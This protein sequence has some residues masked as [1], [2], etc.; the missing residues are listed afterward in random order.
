MGEVP[1]I[2]G[3]SIRESATEVEKL[4]S[5]ADCFSE[6]SGFCEGFEAELASENVFGGDEEES[7]HLGLLEEQTAEVEEEEVRRLRGVSI[8]IESGSGEFVIGGKEAEEEHGHLG[9]LEEKAGVEEEEIRR[10]RRVSVGIE[11]GSWEFAIGGKEAEEEHGVSIGVGEENAD[12]VSKPVNEDDQGG[13]SRLSPLKTSEGDELGLSS[14]VRIGS[15]VSS[16][17]GAFGECQAGNGYDNVSGDCPSAK[18]GLESAKEVERDCSR[19]CEATHTEETYEKLFSLESEK[20][21]CD[22][23]ENLESSAF[24][25]G[26]NVW[27]Q[28]QHSGEPPE[29]VYN[30]EKCTSAHVGV[31]GL[32]SEAVC[33]SSTEGLTFEQQPQHFTSSEKCSPELRFVSDYRGCEVGG[34]VIGLASCF[35][36]V[37][38][39]CGDTDNGRKDDIKSTTM[40]V[41]RR[42]NPKRSASLR[43]N[44]KDGKSEQLDRTRNSGRRCR[45]KV[46]R[47]APLLLATVK[48]S[49]KFKRKRSFRRRPTSLSVWG[50]VDNL[51]KVFKQNGEL[52]TYTSDAIPVKIVRTRKQRSAVDRKNRLRA[53]KDGTKVSTTI[54]DDSSHQPM[55]H[56]LVD[57][58][59]SYEIPASISQIDVGI[60]GMNESNDKLVGDGCTIGAMLLQ[61]D[62]Q[63]VDKDLE[64]TL[65]QETSIDHVV[66]ECP[67]VS[68]QIGPEMLVEAA[69]YRNSL[70]AGTSPES[71]VCHPMLDFGLM[72]SEGATSPNHASVTLGVG[73]VPSENV[74]S[75]DKVTGMGQTVLVLESMSEI[76]MQVADSTSSKTFVTSLSGP[77][78]DS[79]LHTKV[80]GEDN[81]KASGH[82]CPTSENIEEKSDGIENLNKARK[83]SRYRKSKQKNDV[84][85]GNSQLCSKPGK[86]T[87]TGSKCRSFPAESSVL[88]IAELEHSE[89][90]MKVQNFETLLSSGQDISNLKSDETPTS[91]G[92]KGRKLPRSIEPRCSKNGS[93]GRASRRRTNVHGKKKQNAQKSRNKCISKEKSGTFDASL[94][95]SDSMNFSS[96]TA[97]L[98]MTISMCNSNTDAGCKVVPKDVPGSVII[99]VGDQLAPK[100]CNNSLKEQSLSPQLAWV[101]CDDC[102]K[103]RCISVELANAIDETNCKWTCEDNSD[104]AFADC[105]IPQEKTN[106]EI[107]AELGISDEDE[108]YS[109]KPSS[110]G[111]EPP[112]LA[113]SLGALWNAIKCNVFLHRNRRSQTIDEIMV[114]HCKPPRDGS[115]G[116][117]DQC[118]NRMLNIEC[119]KGTCP[120]GN[121][122]SNQQ[123]QKRK[124]GNLKKFHCGKKGYGLQLQEDASCGKFLIEY[125]GEV[126]D[127]ASYEARQRYYASQ[128]QKHFYFMTL[129]GGEVIDACAKG[130]LGRFV[131]HSCDPNCRTE[132]WMV[133]GEVCIGLFAIRDIKKG[134]EVTFDYNYVRVVGAAAKKCVCGSSECRGYIGGDRLNSEVIVQGDSDD[135]DI[136][137]VINHE[138]GERELNL[139]N[140]SDGDGIE[141]VKKEKVSTLTEDTLVKCSLV[142]PEPKI[143]EKIRDIVCRPSADIN[144][145]DNPLPTLDSIQ[146]EDTVSRSMSDIQKLR[147]PKESLGNI[148][149]EETV[150]KPVSVV[151]P[152]QI[153]LESSTRVSEVLSDSVPI[154]RKLITNHVKGKSNTEK[155]YSHTKSSRLSGKIKKGR[156]NVKQF[157]THNPKKLTMGVDNG[158]FEGVEGKLNE[159]LDMDGGISK[160][161]DA[162]RGYLKLLFVTAA[163]GDVRGSAFQSTRDLSLIL[164]AIL[165]TKSRKVL[166]DVINKNG[167]QMLHN[168]MKQ[169]R[170]NF[171]RIPIIRKLLKVLEFL[172]LKG[173]L[174]PDQINRDPPCSGME[175]FKESIL[176]LTRHNDVQVHQIA[177]NFRD[178]WIPRTI[179]KVEQSSRDGSWLD[180]HH[181]CRSWF[182]SSSKIKY[183]HDQ[184]ARGTDSIVISTSSHMTASSVERTV[185]GESSSLGQGVSNSAHVTDNSSAGATRT[186]KRK[187]RWGPSLDIAGLDSQ[188]LCCAEDIDV[189]G[190]K[191][192]K[193]SAARQEVTSQLQVSKQTSGAHGEGNS[194]EVASARNLM[195]QDVNVETPPGFGSPQ[196]TVN[197]VSPPGFGHPQQ[198]VN[199]EAPSGLGSPQEE[200]TSKMPFGISV[201]SGQVVMGHL[202]ERYLS[203]LPVSFGIPVSLMQLGTLETEGGSNCSPFWSVAPTM[204]FHPFPPLPSYPHP[205][206]E[207]GQNHVASSSGK[208]TP[209]TSE[210]PG[211]MSES[212]YGKSRLYGRLKWPSDGPAR[213]FPHQQRWDNQRF[214]RSL[215]YPNQRIAQGFRGNMRDGISNL[216]FQKINRN[217]RGGSCPSKGASNDAVSSNF[218]QHWYHN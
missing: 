208:T 211:H 121:L 57:T 82:L 155:T 73:V 175:S 28:K 133:N 40:I 68:S 200:H 18:I 46:E 117:G 4:G 2:G 205:T 54:Q 104:K 145:L 45:K 74:T 188:S 107:N 129:N 38:T 99:P 106:A 161:K 181:S 35:H 23:E 41:S 27:V 201:A 9:L 131:N 55:F 212:C 164:D 162:T 19:N 108:S 180:P 209:S 14:P 112:K 83:P 119:V 151:Q 125:V 204:P 89:E 13:F 111:A 86:I 135:E 139:K 91:N 77:P 81:G 44:M 12:K 187:S 177:R 132:K 198:H 174:S 47:N 126:L 179:K 115:L 85:N 127:L 124:Y 92:I 48:L 163:E 70:D 72:T 146:S 17:D 141:V 169:N 143:C 150:H 109:A 197:I 193:L 90:Y 158:N 69:N 136:E 203:N 36:R 79:E 30:G 120:C 76:G 84:S 194:D 95:A 5:G 96:G 170:S 42:R 6:K 10:L 43:S 15:E 16:A 167:L 128:G 172:A 173:I 110:K 213:R 1:K 49:D 34:V 3:D 31:Q 183:W 98:E 202:Q 58:R 116:C 71:D 60:S 178:K 122:C 191:C 171:N 66:G 215:P 62:G 142:I 50:P 51:M 24:G 100:E 217:I 206:Q 33:C 22:N 103:W 37:S 165:K 25:Q 8:G 102:Q 105:S 184:G 20:L 97:E 39:S 159:L 26:E 153:S 21:N 168:I 140:T 176:S 32:S 29:E 199:F 152:L 207:R 114:C 64:S 88:G 157:F 196:Q 93:P 149:V 7:G 130:N 137:R 11:S 186:R 192:I 87:T 160:Q 80:R 59:S 216:G 156:S 182:R 78:L 118:L 123:F 67:G 218:H 210:E 154:S 138:V 52:E 144:Q 63:I 113:A 53:Q 61:Q 75:V 185:P 147:G 94:D 214:Q 189:A 134:E 166:V 101:S 65:T 148:P 56:V 190:V 195:H